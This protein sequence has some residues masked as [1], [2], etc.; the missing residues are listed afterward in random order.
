MLGRHLKAIGRY[1]KAIGRYLK[2]AGSNVDTNLLSADIFGAYVN[3]PGSY[4]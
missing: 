1:L 2:V 3:R 4:N